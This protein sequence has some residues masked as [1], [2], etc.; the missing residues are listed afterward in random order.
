MKE[1]LTEVGDFKIGRSD[2]RMIRLLYSELNSRRATRYGKKLVMSEDYYFNTYFNN[3]ELSSI[4]CS[5]QLS[6]K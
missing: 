1:P 4:I 3:N 2:L 5:L 6:R